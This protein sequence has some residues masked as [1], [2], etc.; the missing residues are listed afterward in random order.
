VEGA[1]TRYDLEGLLKHAANKLR[2]KI[3]EREPTDNRKAQT[4][5]PKSK[6]RRA[7][8]LRNEASNGVDRGVK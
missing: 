6:S 4:S 7:A 1:K 5:C 3:K 2:H 8:E